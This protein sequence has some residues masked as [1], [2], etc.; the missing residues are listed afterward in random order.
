MVSNLLG[1]VSAVEA[2]CHVSFEKKMSDFPT[3]LF[4]LFQKIVCFSFFH[5]PLINLQ[6]L[7]SI[8]WPFGEGPTPQLGTTDLD[9]PHPGTASWA[10]VEAFQ[11]SI[12]EWGLY[13]PEGAFLYVNYAGKL[14]ETKFSSSSLWWGSNSQKA[15]PHPSN[16]ICPDKGTFS[17]LPELEFLPNSFQH[18]G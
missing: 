5:N 12:F 11:N 13:S 14:M 2:P 1:P 15:P 18:R 7:I 3:K 10:L 9:D 8:L 16:L 6:P 4:K 17:S